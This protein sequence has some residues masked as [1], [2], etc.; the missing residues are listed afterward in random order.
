MKVNILQKA[1]A[2]RLDETRIR[3]IFTHPTLNGKSQKRYSQMLTLIFPQIQQI[4]L[5][6][7]MQNQSLQLHKHATPYNKMTRPHALTFFGIHLFPASSMLFFLCISHMC[8]HL[9]QVQMQFRFQVQI[10][11]QRV[12]P[13]HSTSSQH[14]QSDPKK[15]PYQKIYALKQSF[16]VCM[17]PPD[18]CI[19][20]LWNYMSILNVT[21]INHP[22]ICLLSESNLINT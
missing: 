19:R 8:E 1:C 5:H 17:S 11:V 4:F 21:A 22:F 7:V 14:I 6:N 10:S 18:F 13:L 2:R 3:Q 20:D 15:T 12:L 16:V 9:I